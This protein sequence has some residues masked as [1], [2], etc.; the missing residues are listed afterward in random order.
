MTDDL[1]DPAR[2]EAVRRPVLEAAT[3]PA[4]CYTSPEFFARERERVFARGWQYVARV[5]EVPRGGYLHGETVGGPVLLLKDSAGTLRAFANTCRHRGA[6]L[7]EGSGTC[8][9][10]VCPYH[11]WSYRLDGSLAGAPGMENTQGFDKAG[12]GLAPV[13]MALWAGFVFVC[14][15]EDTPDLES[16]FGDLTERLKSHRFEEFVCVRRREYDVAANWKLIAENAMEAYHTGS[17]HGASLGQQTARDLVTT[18][19]WDAIQVLGEDSI[20]VL[21][22]E[23]IPFAPVAGL[24]EEAAAGTFFTTLHPNTQFACVQD[25]MWWLTY[26]PVAADRTILQVG[27]CFPRATVERADFAQGA[28]PYFKRWDTGIAEDNTICE[29]QQAGLSSRL[30]RPGRLS[31]H[32]TRVHRLNNW[33]LDQVLDDDRASR[34]I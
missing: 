34:R 10:L 6:R 13:R 25:S 29:A 16:Y 26:R 5:E 2:Y 33:I 24:S 31:E 21:P 8:A 11:A 27:Q 9:R 20:A 14:Y 23:D 32:E 18:G 12:N 28:A 22:G 7:A 19:H 3:L 15:D 1:F 17:V 4:W 30:H